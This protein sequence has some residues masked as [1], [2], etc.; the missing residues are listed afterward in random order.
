M[1][2]FIIFN[3]TH[4]VASE[5]MEVEEE[6]KGFS[7]LPTEVTE[8]ILLLVD[9]QSLLN[10]LQVNK[11]LHNMET[12]VYYD[13]L[14]LKTP[15]NLKSQNDYKFLIADIQ[16]HIFKNI[17]EPNNSYFSSFIPSWIVP[18]WALSYIFPP[19]TADLSEIQ[20]IM[21]ENIIANLTNAIDETALIPDEEVK[22]IDFVRSILQGNIQGFELIYNKYSP[23]HSLSRIQNLYDALLKPYRKYGGSTSYFK[24]TPAASSFEGIS[25]AELI[26]YHNFMV[27]IPGHLKPGI[28]FSDV[29][30]AIYDYLKNVETIT[31]G[32]KKL[33][34]T[35]IEEKTML[36]PC[37]L[38]FLELILLDVGFGENF[39]KLSKEQRYTIIDI[40]RNPKHIAYNDLASLYFPVLLAMGNFDH[41]YKKP[42]SVLL[43]LANKS[44]HEIF[45]QY[46]YAKIRFKQDKTFRGEIAKGAIR[47]GRL[48]EQCFIV[49][50]QPKLD[51][52]FVILNLMLNNFTSFEFIDTQ[53]PRLV[54][55]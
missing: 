20:N 13:S 29:E 11:T 44:P 47:Y 3:S 49:E 25:V 4:L 18:S 31:D 8:R 42:E 22:V 28:M 41:L 46:E 53:I 39:S 2:I 52:L 1:I 5:D 40:I 33:Y 30:S 55:F 26:D 38:R 45:A 51:T 17:E 6:K 27:T 24:G 10:A 12:K 43:A 21:E 37:E 54:S 19:K 16:R 35:V 36:S 23:K 7:S 34:T 48:G 15:F 14:C 50:H 9:P 32:D